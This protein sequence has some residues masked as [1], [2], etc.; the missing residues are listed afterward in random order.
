MVILAVLHLDVPWLHWHEEKGALGSGS[1]VDALF[2]VTPIV[3]FY[4]CSMFCSA[5]LC[6]PSSFAIIL[7]GNRI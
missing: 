7:I 3:C 6:V 5:V 2:I 1:V 4:V